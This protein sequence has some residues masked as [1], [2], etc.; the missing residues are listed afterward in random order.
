M[1]NCNGTTIEC[2]TYDGKNKENGSIKTRRSQSLKLFTKPFLNED[3]IKHK[4]NNNN[5]NFNAKE[6]FS[7]SVGNE[8]PM[9]VKL[10]TDFLSLPASQINSACIANSVKTVNTG[11]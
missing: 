10:K 4:N 9:L 8:K 1:A 5:R 11:D 2:H 6:F 3:S 7:S